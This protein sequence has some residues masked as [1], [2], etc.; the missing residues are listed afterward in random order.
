MFLVSSRPWI[1]KKI[2][3]HRRDSLESTD[4]TRDHV[5]VSWCMTSWCRTCFCTLLVQKYTHTHTQSCISCHISRVQSVQQSQGAAPGSASFT[6]TQPWAWPH[7]LGLCQA[8]SGRG[9]SAEREAEVSKVIKP[10]LPFSCRAEHRAAGGFRESH[11]YNLPVVISEHMKWDREL[12]FLIC[13]SWDF[14]S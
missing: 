14:Y 5:T 13:A 4:P 1:K 2:I 3:I 10:W 11:I 12:L 7:W 8:A 6:Q 9:I